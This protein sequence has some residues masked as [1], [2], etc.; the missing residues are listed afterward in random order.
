MQLALNADEDLVQMPAFARPGSPV[1]Q[2]LGKITAEFL[3]PAPDS[4]VGEGHATFGQDE[5]NIPQAE[6]E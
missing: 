2:L 1:A 4:F 6:A 5:L 3:T